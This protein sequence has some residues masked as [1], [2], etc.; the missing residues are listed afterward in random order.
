MATD[1][2]QGRKGRI[3]AGFVISF[4]LCMSLLECYLLI[5]SQEEGRRGVAGIGWI[6]LLFSPPWLLSALTS[7]V[8]FWRRPLAWLPMLLVILTVI[9]LNPIVTALYGPHP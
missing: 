3:L 7:L 5:L 9:F 6:C 4:A 8:C 1:M 2:A